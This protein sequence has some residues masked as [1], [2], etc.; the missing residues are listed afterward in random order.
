MKTRIFNRESLEILF[1]N[2]DNLTFENGIKEMILNIRE[3]GNTPVTVNYERHLLTVLKHAR[4]RRDN[5][6]VLRKRR[7]EKAEK[8][9]I[10]LRRLASRGCGRSYGY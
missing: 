9:K 8:A 7:A 2:P 6:E 4:Y 3:Q 5:L 10:A 1:G